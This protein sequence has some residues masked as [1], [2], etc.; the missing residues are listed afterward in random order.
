MRACV[1]VHACVRVC[2]C[3]CVR[4]CVH[5]CVCAR[6]CVCVRACVRACVVS[7]VVM[8]NVMHTHI[9]QLAGWWMCQFHCVWVHLKIFMTLHSRGLSFIHC[10]TLVACLVDSPVSQCPVSLFGVSQDIQNVRSLNAGSLNSL[11]SGLA[12][13]VMLCTAFGPL[14]L[15]YSH[16]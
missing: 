3:V 7:L 9:H 5:A 2:M 4:V 15:K 1:C 6:A 16:V 12:S 8:F 10:R 11:L 14:P 13:R